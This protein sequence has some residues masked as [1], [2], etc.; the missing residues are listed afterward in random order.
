MKKNT[1]TQLLSLLT[2]EEL[3]RLSKFLR[4][5]YFNYS[6]PIITLFDCLRKWH[7]DYEERRI[8]PRMYWKKIQPEK[9]FSE[10][11]YWILN[12]KLRRLIERFMAIEKM[13]GNEMAFKK[14]LIKAYA[15]RDAHRL[16]END[17]KKLIKK[18]DSQPHRDIHAYSESLWLKHDYFFNPQTDKYKDVLFSVENTME[19]LDRFY[20]LAKLRFS[21][22]MK[23]REKIFSKKYKIQL[24][25]EII[26]ASKKYEKENP[27]FLLYKKIL[28]LYMPEKSEAAFK[29]GKKLLIKKIALIGRHDQNEILLN[30]RN[31]AIRQLNNGKKE[32]WMEVFNL[33]KLGLELDLILDNNRLSVNAYS[34]IVKAG[35]ESR[36]FRWTENFIKKYEVCLYGKWR[37]DAKVHSLGSLYFYKKNMTRQLTF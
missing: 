36:Q 14:Q 34:N 18:I 1:A 23:N 13:E 22:E 8:R 17:T 24:L 33:Y 28:E 11:A 37:V 27:V 4:S 6:Q 26:V 35:C 10:N 3:R 5:P 12:F 15:D 31:Y 30:L 7:P 20:F 19:E 16:F 29:E 25:D 2:E 32:Y 21:T 9:P